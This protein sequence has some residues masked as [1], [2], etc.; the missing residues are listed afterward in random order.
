MGRG[1]DKMLK[2]LYANIIEENK[3]TG[4]YLLKSLKLRLRRKQIT[5]FERRLKGDSCKTIRKYLGIS[6][7]EMK[8]LDYIVESKVRDYKD[9]SHK[10]QNATKDQKRLLNIL[11]VIWQHEN[12]HEF[13]ED[14]RRKYFGEQGVDEETRV[15]LIKTLKSLIR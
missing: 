4:G 6:S 15:D 8:E 1:G 9:Q 10:L 5:V 3:K 12:Y 2:K 13:D 14:Q 11:W 7:D